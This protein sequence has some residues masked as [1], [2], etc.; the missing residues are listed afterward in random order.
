MFRLQRSG[1]KP[2]KGCGRFAAA[3]GTL[4]FIAACTTAVKTEISYQE[5]VAESPVTGSPYSPLPKKVVV[6]KVRHFENIS[7][8]IA[9]AG[10]TWYFE[11]GET[12]GMTGFSSAF[13]QAGNDWIGNDADKGYNLSPNTGGRHEYRGWPNFGEGNFNHPQ[14]PSNSTSYWVDKSGKKIDFRGMLKGN[15]LVMISENPTYKLEYHFFPSHAAIKVLKADDKYAF[16]FEG[17]V[18]GE[19]E[20]SITKDYYV[21]KD[22]LR[23]KLID[24]G[25]GYLPPKFGNRF[26]SPFFY[27]VDSDPKD[28]QV[29]YIGVKNGAPESAGDEAWRQGKNMVIFSYGRDEN[30]RAYTGTDAVSVFGFYPKGDHETI[31]NFIEAKLA[32]PF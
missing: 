11:T 1:L 17:P 10:G 5:V 15:H 19:Q 20:E 21:L 12:E 14:R 29:L 26:P 16:L 23:R 30:K 25:L 3:A 13:D 2:I 7:W 4:I 27:L 31:S 6:T 18:G 28:K 8:K 32:N 24:G 22:G 9:A